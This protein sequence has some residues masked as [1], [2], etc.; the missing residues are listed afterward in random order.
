VKIPENVCFE[1]QADWGGLWNYTWRTGL[2]RNGEPV[3]GSMY[4]HLWS[5]GPKECLEFADYSFDQHFGRPI[6][7]YP[8]REV[9]FDYIKGRA[10][11]SGI[12]KY[13]EFGTVARWVTYCE[14]TGKF[15]VAVERLADNTTRE[16]TFDRLI[17]ASGHFSTPNVPHFEGIEEFPGRV[18]HAHDYRNPDEFKGQ[19]LLMIGSSYSAEDIG[20]QC[21]KHG[22]KSVTFTYR[23]APM[24]FDWPEGMREVPLLERLEGG[25]AHF[26]DGSSDVF[27]A[28]I[29]CTGYLHTFPFLEDRLRLETHN[30]L[31]PP[32]LYKGVI[33]KDQPQLAYLGMQDQY[34]TFTMFDA[35]AWY[36]RD[37]ILGRIPLPSTQDMEAD[38]AAWLQRE[39]ALD[40]PFDDVDFQ[41]DYIRD[42]VQPTDYPTFDLDA[43]AR[44]F[45]RW[46]GEKEEDIVGYRDEAYASVL[47]GT[48]ASRHVRP[49]YEE[50]DDSAENFLRPR[51]R[52]AS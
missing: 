49:W 38:I 52:K 16:E 22:A 34:Y 19:R 32:G 8:P 14:E 40:G 30:R 6:P 35:Q 29:L 31:F 41:T 9:L 42:L 21:F 28:I 7:S 33:W 37:V 45:K 25:R 2:D 51:K 11:R 36:V 27:D 39:E 12:R 18:L 23:T 26:K 47:T 20:L 1:Q 13:I 17:V 50:L 4:R 44:Y 48:K 15:T 46:L 5:N 10:E 24:G 43:V 3:H